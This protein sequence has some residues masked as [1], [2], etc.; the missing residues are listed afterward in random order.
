MLLAIPVAIVSTEGAFFI[1][2]FFSKKKVIRFFILLI[3]IFSI[4]FTSATY[5]IQHNTTVWPTSSFFNS[6]QEAF[7]YGVWFN[8]IPVNE[9]VFMISRPKIAVG[10]GKYSCN[11]CQEEIELRKKII[12]VS[13]KELHGFLKS[14]DYKY[15][16]LSIKND[17][18]FF[19][20]EVGEEKSLGVLQE[21][22]NDFINSGLFEP[23]YQK[24]GVFIALTVK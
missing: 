15:L 7:E 10:F 5:K 22:Y 20:K 2:D 17:L 8:S 12:N 16:L 18:K 1:K 19:K 23:V 4:F 14:K 6:P 9:K 11:W 3:I 13:A 24:E 21:K